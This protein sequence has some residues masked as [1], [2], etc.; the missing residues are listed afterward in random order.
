[1]RLAVASLAVLAVLSLGALAAPPAERERPCQADSEKFC[2]DVKPGGGAKVRCLAQHES[3]LSGAC[4]ENLRRAKAHRAKAKQR[5]SEFF[6]ACKSDAWRL[7]KSA[8]PGAGRVVR[9]L[10]DKKDELSPGCR[11]KLSQARKRAP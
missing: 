8:S 3:E 10:T 9:C 6:E 1:M 7:C 5:S 11:E 2:K 4:R